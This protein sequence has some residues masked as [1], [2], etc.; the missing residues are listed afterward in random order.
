MSSPSKPDIA[1]TD[2]ILLETYTKADALH[3][4][5]DLEVYVRAHVFGSALPEDDEEQQ[6]DEIFDRWGK[7]FFSQ[8][9][10]DNLDKQFRASEREINNLATMTVF[11]P[12]ALNKEQVHKLA[13]Q[14]RKDYKDKLLLDLR[15]DDSLISGCAIVWEGNYHDYSIKG[16]WGQ[17]ESVIEKKLAKKN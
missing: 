1:L 8:F 7:G 9:S 13:A 6:F 10:V 11:T 4:L 12:V 14:L 17:I 5:H 2:R 3:L 16:Q 15:V